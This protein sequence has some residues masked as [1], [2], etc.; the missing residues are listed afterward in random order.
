MPVT[1][2][3]VI[4]MGAAAAA[5]GLLIAFRWRG[6]RE[7]PGGGDATNAALNGWVLVRPDDKIEIGLSQAEM[8]QG[9]YNVL[10]QIVADELDVDLDNVVVVRTPIE[11]EYRFI[12][13][14]KEMFTAG[15]S[16]VAFGFDMLRKAGASARYMLVT[17]AA[18]R[19]DVPYSECS[20]SGGT[21]VHQAS[22]RRLPYGEIAN[23]AA[24]LKSPDDPPLKADSDLR[25]IGKPMRR[26]D[27]APKVTGEA[28]FAVDVRLP[29]MLVATVASAP[30][31]GNRIESYDRGAA[32]AVPGVV[33]V[34]ELPARM[35]EIDG[36][37]V[38]FAPAVAVVA[39]GYWQA[40][41]GID[42]SAPT[43][44]S[45][46]N[47]HVDDAW[48]DECYRSALDSGVPMVS[49]NKGD[50][51]SVIEAPGETVSADYAVP[52]L[53]HAAMEPMSCV[54]KVSS[55]SVAIWTGTQGIELAQRVVST[56]LDRERDTVTIN[57][58]FL[59]GAFGRR[60]E[61]D[62]VAQ[63]AMIAAAI[64]DRPVKLIWSREEDIRHDFYRPAYR[65]RLR[66]RLGED[67]LPLAL[68]A[69][70]VGQHIFKHSPSFAALI[71]ED[72]VD[73]AAVEGMS[74]MP[75]SI[76]NLRVE[77][78]EQALHVPVGWWRSV[79]TSQNA[80]FRE[81]F[82]DR[83]AR[84]TDSDPI[85]YRRRLLA[86]HPR[87]LAVL[88]HVAELS[89]WRSAPGNRY[90]GVAVCAVFGTIVG[91]VAEISIEAG[92]LRV[93][94]LCIA[95][96]CGRVINPDGADAQ[97]RGAAIFGL[98]A[99]LSGEISIDGGAVKQS[100]FHDYPIRRMRDMPD[101]E[102]ALI[103]SG[104]NLSG[105]GES[106]TPQVAPAIANAVL[107]GTGQQ[108]DELPFSRHFR[109]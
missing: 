27:V 33:E 82:I 4:G 1:R 43:F 47:S 39:A 71:G 104:G 99:A 91:Q 101:I 75:Y 11:A 72:G 7:S 57:N 81:T 86:D 28:T 20:T 3:A 26:F 51:D 10:P 65:A 52:Y 87:Y 37:E 90:Q 80:F 96:D 12:P 25:Y 79:G 18:A 30:I 23:E 21:V 5:G 19:W 106:A 68:E 63:A 22:G 88:D 77:Y 42:A 73:G 95:A 103:E 38:P 97:L 93:H 41:R 17:A 70:V 94:R 8:G 13:F 9:V 56:L 2:R 49:L 35:I 66:A 105:L 64:P 107:A 98:D 24:A 36:F 6:R 48:I 40:K 89:G 83:L 61:P 32:K 74:T 34:V 108:I 84:L 29:D 15:S 50:T 67:G 44:A 55:D 53:A 46:D 62:F 76:P 54:A 45:D 109:V 100:N 78:V 60:Y 85:E 14:I 92:R 31:F 102:V 69:R 16:S 59:G 58:V